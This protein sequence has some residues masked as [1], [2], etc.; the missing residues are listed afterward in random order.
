M[1]TPIDDVIACLCTEQL[2]SQFAGVDLFSRD[3]V[4]VT[5]PSTWDRFPTIHDLLNGIGALPL[6]DG[7]P[8]DLVGESLAAT[9]TQYAADDTPSI[10]DTFTAGIDADDRV[11]LESGLAAFSVKAL[12]GDILGFE[13]TYTD[14]VVIG[15][16][17]RVT[18]PNNFTRGQFLCGSD[19]GSGLISYR[20]KYGATNQEFD[21]F[22]PLGRYPGVLEWV[23]E[24]SESDRLGNA[25]LVNLSYIDRQAGPH[26]T[27]RWFLNASGKVCNSY[28]SF[29]DPLVWLSTEFRDWLGF[30]GDETPVADGTG[31]YTLTATDSPKGVLW[32][33]RPIEYFEP[34]IQAAKNTQPLSD[35]RFEQAHIST[36]HGWRLRFAITGLAATVDR[37]MDAEEN[38]FD[39]LWRSEYFTVFL[40]VNEKRMAVRE[41]VGYSIEVSGQDDKR[42]GAHR[43]VLDPAI[44][45]AAFGLEDPEVRLRY[46][47]ELLGWNYVTA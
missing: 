39:L 28:P 37:L 15:T 2:V 30:R 1:P 19:P 35:G 11:Y 24:Q 31:H 20:V 44:A 22:P 27:T 17:R 10:V 7:T 29:V 34:E 3:A 41:K 13:T 9:V 38:F 26:V 14:S 4:T 5:A 12:Y 6:Y 40:N 16:R 23:R 47:L 45:S 36:I 46:F 43:L 33:D 42:M 25:N 8:A 21:F 18:A 32:L